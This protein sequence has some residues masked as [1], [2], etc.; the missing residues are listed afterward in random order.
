MS[1]KPLHP[2]SA[3]TQTPAGDGPPL[4]PLVHAG[5]APLSPAEARAAALLAQLPRPTPLS[6]SALA[7]I[8]D[9]IQAGVAPR[10]S[11]LA[12]WWAGRLAWGTATVAASFVLGWSLR[13]PAPIASRTPRT[14]AAVAAMNELRVP[15]DSL[16]RVATQHGDQLTL[17]GPGSLQILSDGSTLQLRDGQLTVEGG[18]QAVQIRVGGTRVHLGPHGHA[19]LTA[20]LGELVYV[21]AYVGTVHV[22]P[23][24]AEAQEH[25]FDVPAGGSWSRPV[26]AG[27][28]QAVGATIAPADAP[29]PAATPAT[30]L[31]GAPPRAVRPARPATHASASIA[32]TAG[33]P[34]VAG[35]AGIGSPTAAAPESD[36][37]IESQLLGQALQQLH[38]QRDGQAA[39]RVLDDYDRR[40]RDGSLRQE[41]QAARVDALLL[42]DRQTEALSI[43][44]GAS[45]TRLA[46]GGEL[47]LVR[48]ELRAHAGRCRDALGDFD[49][50]LSDGK[51][52]EKLSERALYGQATCRLTL[53]DRSLARDAF[54]RYLDRFPAGRFSDAARD[55]LSRL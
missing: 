17:S 37:L 46:R 40:F 18:A 8:E 34:K 26:V 25:A 19:A 33:T 1:D 10:G 51:R 28:V 21:A 24:A 29:P 41:A 53:G 20:R 32:P 11:R 4:L 2:F 30:A 39:L 38:R 6:A 31:I 54:R 49:A 55:A 15:A 47:R 27:A 9:R 44:D 7:R 14:D 36:L 43:L 12:P 45:F 35:A 48:G 22:A 23:F 52:D 3:G 5:D 42:L 16:A 13:S 50:A